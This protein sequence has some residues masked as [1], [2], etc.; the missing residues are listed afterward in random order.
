MSEN[1]RDLAEYQSDHD[2]L[3]LLN[4]RVGKLTEALEKKTGDHETRIRVL[5]SNT[6]QWLGKQSLIGGAIGTGVSI[7]LA[8]LKP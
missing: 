3:I 1:P 4:E 5:E 6:N 2:L 7:A 8:L